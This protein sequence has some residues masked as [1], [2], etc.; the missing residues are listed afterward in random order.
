[1][2]AE[3]GTEGES[4]TEPEVIREKKTEEGAAE[5]AAQK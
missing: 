4:P 1:V 3:P 2:A 5:N